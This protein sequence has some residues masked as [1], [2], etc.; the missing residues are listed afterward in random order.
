MLFARDQDVHP[1]TQQSN[2]TNLYQIIFRLFYVKANK[3]VEEGEK[4]LIQEDFSTLLLNVKDDTSLEELM[5]DYFDAGDPEDSSLTSATA[6]TI[7]EEGSKDAKAAQMSDITVAELPPVLQIHLIRTQFDK[8]DKTSY[9]SNATVAL[10]KRIYLD[11]YL[12]S[13]Q[14]EQAVRFKRIKLWKKERRVCR[15]LLDV[16]KKPLLRQGSPF[17][18]EITQPHG[19]PE[20][21]AAVLPA[22]QLNPSSTSPGVDPQPED[23]GTS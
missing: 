1:S 8:R 21:D 17:M 20:A 16:K 4:R 7:G 18:G 23:F 22:D 19:S 9:K 10:P 11:Q 12:E 2:A 3:K 5:D 13:N 14:E 15:K 6:A